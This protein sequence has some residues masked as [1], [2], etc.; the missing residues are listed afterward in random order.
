[1]RGDWLAAGKRDMLLTMFTVYT[2]AGEAPVASTAEVMRMLRQYPFRGE[3]DYF[4]IGRLDKEYLEIYKTNAG[5]DLAHIPEGVDDSHLVGED[6]D[7]L[8]VE[9][10]ATAFCDGDPRWEA[11]L[12]PAEKPAAQAT[13]KS[14]SA[15]APTGAA[16]PDFHHEAVPIEPR[17]FS[18]SVPLAFFIFVTIMLL[19]LAATYFLKP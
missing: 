19:G 17:A 1:M 5:F 13:A 8:L 3:V 11:L 4:T 14:F 6:L 15:A 7:Y 12:N 2:Q 10:V 9:R 16:G 18:C